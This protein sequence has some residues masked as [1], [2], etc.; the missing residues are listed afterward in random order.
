MKFY[1]MGGHECMKPTPNSPVYKKEGGGV[2]AETHREP[3]LQLYSPI[4][5]RL[6]TQILLDVQRISYFH[7]ANHVW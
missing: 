6:L 3:E 1:S 4:V 5:V 2:P 7:I